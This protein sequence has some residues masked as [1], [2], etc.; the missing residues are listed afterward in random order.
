MHAILKYICLACAVLLSSSLAG[1]TYL[2]I[3]PSIRQAYDLITQ[4][5]MEAA[6]E[7]LA[8]IKAAEPDNMMVH[9]MEHYIDF[10]EV[11]I[12]EDKE[13]FESIEDRLD[14]R[15]D[16]IESA[17]VE[18]PYKRFVLAEMELMWALIR[19]KFGG[20]LSVLSGVTKANSLLK[21]NVHL[22]PDFEENKKSLSILHAIAE[23]MPR[24]LRGL[25]GF[26]GSIEEGTR[27]ILSFVQHAQ[28]HGSLF[29]EESVVV[30][31]YIL[32]YLN[33]DH[34]AAWAMLRDHPLDIK[35]NPL[36]TFIYSNMAQRTGQNDLAI[37]M[38][39]ERVVAED[40]IQFTYLDFLHG[41]FKLYRLDDDADVYMQRFIQQF[42]GKHFVKEAYQKL[43]WHALVVEGDES[44]Y[45]R[46]MK[47]CKKN[48]DDLVDEDKQAH[49]EAKAKSAPNATLLKARLL[50]DGGYLA[51]A[52]QLLITHAEQFPPQ[53][54][55]REAYLYRLGRVLHGLKN[56]PEALELYSAV[57]QEYP[58]SKSFY[59]CN[60]TLQMG[61]ICEDQHRY[62]EA[63]KHYNHC[64]AIKSSTY[65][66]SLHQKARAGVERVEH[67]ILHH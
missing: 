43:A 37:Q 2:D 57:Y 1:Q 17:A 24:L 60:A 27:E 54:D 11:F 26:Q 10:F 15:L 28:A 42:D 55:H 20:R 41:K 53:S 66:S 64:L 18:G 56:Y 7:E 3:S 14:D 58:K 5:R 19:S 32:F 25:L 31:S 23:S 47:Q 59:R 62:Q 35:T 36:L 61:Y 16:A 52:H 9:H 38:L 65:R 46:Y 33:N 49:K 50:Y 45:H 48:G 22:Y 6:H 21:E 44:A 13:Y 39:E 51:R 67:K 8:R 4:L 34:D 12:S 63:L 30:A 40:Q 29:Y